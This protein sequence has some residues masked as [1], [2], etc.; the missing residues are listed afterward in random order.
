MSTLSGGPNIVTNGLVLSLD[1]ANPKS[2]VSG[3][4]TWNDISRVGNNGTLINGPTF[5]SGNYGS[6]VF[7][8]TNDYVII[9]NSNTLNITSTIT[10][11]SW[12]KPT[13]LANA[14]HGDGIFSKGLSSDGNSGV[15]ETLMVQSGSFN[16]PFFRLR[17]G[18]STPTYNPNTPLTLNQIYHFVSTYDGSTMNI[19]ING[20]QSGA[21]LFTPG[22]IQSNT[23]ELTLGVRYN[24]ISD[25]YFN[26]NVYSGKIYN[27][28]LS[29]AEVL[30][31][32]NS[33]R[34]R[35]GI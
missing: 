21:G 19:Y 16:T 1:A 26:G 18:S 10:L 33:T 2:Y 4:T 20:V 11:E 12:I 3:S 5:N 6:I 24:R 31:N 35:F 27:R 34:S 13:A 17:I 22:S 23:Q 30:Q 28:A 14:S 32:F 29:A 9:S 8:G 15:Y 7:D 25:S